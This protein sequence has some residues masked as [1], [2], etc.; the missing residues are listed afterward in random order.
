MSCTNN[1]VEKKDL[2]KKDLENKNLEQKY[3]EQNFLSTPVHEYVKLIAL[4]LI[5]QHLSILTAHPKF[6]HMQEFVQNSL[7]ACIFLVFAFC[8]INSNFKL[9]F[10]IIC[11]IAVFAIYYIIHM[12][13][14]NKQ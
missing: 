12:F 7:A 5:A 3:L 4:V 8:L 6:L 10:S 2:D 14:P 13:Y 9:E 1:P 11:T